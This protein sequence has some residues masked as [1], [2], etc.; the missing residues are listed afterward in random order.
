[1]R[2]AEG[3]IRMK[4]IILT[5][6]R[7]YFQMGQQT[8]KAVDGVDVRVE[9]QTSCAIV[10]PSGSGKSTLINL[11]GL[12]LQPDEGSIV[13]NGKPVTS[14]NDSER[15]AMRNGIFG[16]IV[17]DFALIDN[18]SVYRNIQ[19]PLLYAKGIAR[20]EHG[21]RIR[22]VAGKLGIEDK[23][24]R[25][26]GL[27]SGGERQRVA[28]ARAMVCDQPIIL[29]DEPTGALDAENKENVLSIL[30]DQARSNGKML[31]IVTHDLTIA[32]RCDRVIAMRNGRIIDG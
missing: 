12:I 1:M 21:A 5:G 2:R 17:Q 11:M 7:K 18:E 15:S 4:S 26:T 23:L 10:G 24:R 30:M 29:A 28:I 31:I 16:Y 13:V 3:G 14:L 8:V 6:V 25:K 27:L 9:G 22:A 20:K 19:I 32:D